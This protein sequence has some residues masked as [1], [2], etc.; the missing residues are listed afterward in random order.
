MFPA[1]KT[2]QVRVCSHPVDRNA[3]TV[4][5]CD[6]LYKSQTID[7]IVKD[8]SPKGA[9]L[10]VLNG[11]QID[12]EQWKK[13]RV[14]I[15]CTVDILPEVG[16][17][18]FL[19]WATSSLF[20][21]T[22]SSLVINIA[23]GFAF[24]YLG[25]KLFGQD[26][27]E[28]EDDR[29]S[30]NYAWNPKTSHREGMP[31]PRL[32][33]ETMVHGNVIATWTDVVSD[34]EVLYAVVDHGEG[35]IEGIGSNIVYIN[36]QPSGNY[37]GVTV[38][39][40]LGTMD[41]T[42]MTGFEKTKVEYTLNWE[43][44]SA[45]GAQTFTT[46]NNWADDLEWTIAFPNGLIRYHK[47]GEQTSKGVALKVEISERGLNSWTTVYNS[48]ITGETRRPFYKIFRAS[49][50]GFTCTH[51]KQYDIR[52]TRT[53]G[54]DSERSSSTTH[55]KSVREV[56]NT[57][58]TYPGRALVGVTAVGTEQLSG[59]L[60]IKCVRQGRI[61]N[62]Y[63][64]SS[65]SLKYSNNLAWCVLDILT[66]P[67]LSGSND[68][69]DAY[70]IER[71]DGVNPANIDLAFFYEWAALCDTQVSDGK[72]SVESLFVC[73]YNVDQK[74]SVF[75]LAYEL[76][77]VGRCKLYWE[78]T[79]LTGWLDSAVLTQAD[80]VTMDNIMART[81]KN[82]WN[83]K[84]EMAG[85]IEVSYTDE[86]R[87]HERTTYLHSNVNSGVYSNIVSV[88]AS[89]ETRR[90][91]AVR[92][93]DFALN[94]NQLI[95]NVNSF[96]MHKDA[97]RYKLGD[98]I[99]LQCKFPNWGKNYR[100]VSVDSDL[101][102]VTLDRNIDGV[103]SGDLLYVRTYDDTSG[104]E[105]VDISVYTVA[106]VS[107]K[108][109]TIAETFDPLPSKDCI[110]AIGSDDSGD[111]SSPVLRRI[112]K[113][114]QRV[115]NFYE[116]TAETYDA[117][118]YDGI[119]PTNPN[120]DYVWPAPAKSDG[121]KSKP[122]TWENILDTINA[123][124]PPQP[125]IDIPWIS[126]CEWSYDSGGGIVSWSARDADDPIT[127]RYRG[128][129][130]E[131]TADSS[132]KEFIYWDPD[133]TDRFIGTD[134][135][136]VALATGNWLVCGVVDG[137]AYP[138]TPIQFL[139]AGVILAG[140]IRAEQYAELRQTMPWMGGDSCDAT[141]PY[142]FD[143]KLPSE[144]TAIISAKLSFKIKDFRAYSTAAASVGATVGTSGVEN[145]WPGQTGGLYSP[146]YSGNTGNPSTNPDTGNATVTVPQTTLHIASYS[147]YAD[148]TGN[149]RHEL[150]SYGDWYMPETGCG[151]HAHSLPNHAHSFN[152]PAHTHEFTAPKHTHSVTVPTHSHD[153]TF[154]IYEESNATNVHYHIDNG[155]GFGGA[156]S[157]YNSDQTDIDI[158]ASISNAGWK[159]IRFDVDA[160]CRITAILEVKV[161]ITA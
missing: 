24:S 2:F 59:N 14:K 48:T 10:V 80:L 62:T 38:Q 34:N 46:P 68:S 114:V 15:G 83:G 7:Q 43:L 105:D 4:K 113:I 155:A 144:L 31:R 122:I 108:F 152:V 6:V 91:G 106:S 75:S 99:R 140:T 124:R 84:E 28:S 126:N 40:R 25:G 35:P 90:S 92:L 11:K 145:S 149:H 153:L 100:I 12:K 118:L 50:L 109:L 87:G 130:Y 98:V 138:S 61:V 125:D 23:L 121:I 134:L 29:G 36:D 102:T 131:I 123:V 47:D 5:T 147:Q 69:G 82:A 58:F 32:Y 129:T 119:T 96:D 45:G 111:T 115:D 143:F 17:A 103:S 156:S 41:Q 60:D 148:G 77:Q 66:Q 30:Q 94:R 72:G 52:F 142:T 27:K 127:F 135:A 110:V 57:A 93:A 79:N 1:S 132:D 101:Q 49:T 154:G 55:I 85:T 63:D 37:S 20:W 9:S 107:G 53:T 64:G 8:F 146:P 19:F 56:S 116:V 141:H 150:S 44:T 65:W 151:T 97:L 18:F 16:Y 22:V 133:Y 112:V 157:S 86:D 21:S 51:G 160:R 104:T 139:H 117:D 81:W 128:T 13:T 71:Y 74:R 88:E 26:L 89:A 137:I 159:S 70:T 78:G 54:A 120:S 95:R 3:N 33:G 73:N 39:E 67:V 161:D 42:C 76:S 136:S 158:T